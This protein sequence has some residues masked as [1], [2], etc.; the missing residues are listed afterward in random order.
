[1]P[2]PATHLKKHCS[3]LNALVLTVESQAGGRALGQGDLSL[4]PNCDQPRQHH[5]SRGV[6]IKGPLENLKQTNQ[7]RSNG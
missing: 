1:M 2:Q 5:R 6:G 4:A 3:A 7:P